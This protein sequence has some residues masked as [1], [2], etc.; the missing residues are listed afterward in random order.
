MSNNIR[1]VNADGVHELMVIGTAL[2]QAKDLITDNK[3]DDS[4]L[5]LDEAIQIVE[6]IIDDGFSSV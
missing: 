4:Y 6:K 5:Q 2:K 3:L 1:Q